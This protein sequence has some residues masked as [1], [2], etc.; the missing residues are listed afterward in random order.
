MATKKKLLQAAA[1]AAGGAAALNVEDVFSTYL[2]TGTGS[3]TTITNGIDLSGEGGMVWGK[4]RTSGVFNHQIMD[5]ERGTRKVLVSNTTDAEASNGDISA[6]NSDGFSLSTGNNLM[7]SNGQDFASWTFR[8]APKFFDVVTYTGNG[9]AG[10]TVSHNLGSVPGCIIVKNLDTGSTDWSTYHRTQGATKYGKLNTT[11]AFSGAFTGQWNETEP[12]DSVFT[13]G[14]SLFVNSNGDNYVA[15]L[16]AHND[17]D[18]EFGPDGDADI[19]KCGSYTGGTSG[20][21]IDL[22]FEP[23]WLL[24]KS[25]DSANSWF[26]VDNMRG[27]DGDNGSNSASTVL[28]LNNIGS[29]NT[30]SF[31]IA[32]LLPNGFTINS[33]NY[34][35]NASGEDYI[36]IAIRRGPMA[37][38]ESATDVFALDGTYSASSPQY[39]SG[40][41]VDF[42]MRRYDKTSGTDYV[43]AMD[44]LRG[45]G[46]QYLN[47]T[48]TAAESFFS[49]IGVGQMDG[50]D[51]NGTSNSMAWLWRRAPNFFDVVAYTGNG[52][53]QTINHNLGVV[54]EMIITKKRTGGTASWAVVLS[55]LNSGLGYLKLDSTDQLAATTYNV[56]PNRGATTYDCNADG[57]TNASGST[58]IAYL[59]ASLDGVS[60]VGS[61]TGNGSTTGPSIDCGFSTGPRFVLIKRT[62]SAENWY[63]FDSERGIV[64][65]ADP[66]LMLN[67]TSAE[68][69]AG[70][71]ID[72][73]SSGFQ[74]ATNG[75][76][77][78]ASGATYIFY[79]IA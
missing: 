31:H 28:R 38:P 42:W 63:M 2:Y 5:T 18:G 25:V 8:K 44:R 49:T 70:D 33:V 36:Y 40:W 54:P 71:I 72:P 14:D 1:G 55:A 51:L 69:N 47:T 57:I 61:Y 6:F 68:I 20:I 78:N 62:D 24:I 10:R 64:A 11:G 23:Q 45:N 35:S 7:L 73:T 9:V 13:V 32:Q 52:S 16:F 15:Y 60:K 22:G 58:Y 66:Y 30:A 67:S 50:A 37:V 21:E 17:G 53:T 46:Q 41:P 75:S 19:I 26:C 39:Y 65:G 4:S 77:V 76:S 3:A 74:L 27:F 48:S 79:A 43:I 29:E 12:T 34:E 59:F 56:H